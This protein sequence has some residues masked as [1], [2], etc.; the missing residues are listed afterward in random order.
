VAILLL[1]ALHGEL[2]RVRTLPALGFF[3]DKKFTLSD[4]TNRFLQSIPGKGESRSFFSPSNPLADDVQALL[5]EYQYAGKG[6]LDVE[7]HQPGAQFFA[8]EGISSTNTK[9]S[10]VRP[11]HS[12]LR[13]PEQDREG[14]RDGEIDPGNPMLTSSQRSRRSRASKR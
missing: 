11:S 7:K 3:R 8:G 4:K 14:V 2:P 5:T 9:S 13:R 12:R 1:I 10:P 6:K